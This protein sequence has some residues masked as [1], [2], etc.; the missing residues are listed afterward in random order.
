M[1]QHAAR[2]H[3]GSGRVVLHGAVAIAI[4]AFTSVAYLPLRKAPYIQDDRVAVEHN[5]IVA[6][7]DLAEI[8]G[9]AYWAHASGFSP[10]LY[11]PVTILSFALERAATGVPD[12]H[13]SHA[14]DVLL[15][16]G[17]AVLL[18]LLAHRLG[19]GRFGAVAAGVLFAVHPIHVEPVAS[20]VGRAELLAAFFVLLGLLALSAARSRGDGSRAG[21]L[22]ARALSWTAGAALLLALGAKEVAVVG[23]P[24]FALFVLFYDRPR[25]PA[26]GLRARLL[27]AAG[28]LTPA[29]AA[30]LLYLVVRTRAIEAF[31]GLQDPAPVDNIL[32]T[33]DG[34]RRLATAL[35]F[36]T[37]YMRLLVFP[38]GLS[39]DYSGRALSPAGALSPGAL[40]GLGI[41]LAWLLV[42]LAPLLAGRD[43][44]GEP[45][46]RT[47]GLAGALFLLPYGVVGNLFSL[48]GAA[49][50]ERL[51]YLP[52]LGFCLLFGLLLGRMH[53]RLPRRAA[54]SRLGQANLARWIVAL[55]LGAFAL[56]TWQRSTD[57]T[58][59][60]RLFS[61]AV[62]A[63]PDAPRSH[64]I[65]GRIRDEQGRPDEAL[66]LLERTVDLWPDY[67]PA[68]FR[69]G[70]IRG[71]RQQL[72][73]AEEMFAGAIRAAP[74][75]AV[76]HLDLGVALYRQGR[77]REAERW[78]RKA[79]IYD[80]QQP[81]AWATL[82]F[83]LHKDG[84]FVEATHAY[85]RAI[86]LGRSDLAP[87]LEAAARGRQAVP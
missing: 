49:F 33:L 60:E 24:L 10:T 29:V 73:R 68:W 55:F 22:R 74:D 61:A 16:A 77:M 35:S 7:G 30:F 15:H 64:F 9:S 71:R 41:L 38:I 76:A 36:A 54:G 28:L 3:R 65:L 48:V 83:I 46:V 80:A 11:R 87:N 5:P 17:V 40:F 37:R 6:R 53:E 39:A 52:S 18:Y 27:E 32:V 84:R 31:P 20:V 2:G 69:M 58:S 44:A 8:V 19:A 4:V 62:R 79:L 66:G 85:R 45:A 67:A 1:T 12:A 23:L 70:L 56:L 34:P 86:A 82:G 51:A 21:G 26:V 25:T 42:A 75:L 47:A 14:V 50:A 57:W 43:R 72:E 81:G 13:V 63:M 59:E 78:L